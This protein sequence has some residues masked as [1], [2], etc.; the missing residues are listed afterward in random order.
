MTIE[1]KRNTGQMGQ[2][3]NKLQVVNLN[4]S[5]LLMS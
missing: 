2:I 5:R 4:P 3:E 1:E